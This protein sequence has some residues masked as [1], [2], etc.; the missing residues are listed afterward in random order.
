MSEALEDT[1][2][3]LEGIDQVRCQNCLGELMYDMRLT[4]DRH[5][6]ERLCAFLF[7][8]NRLSDQ[9]KQVVRYCLDC[10]RDLAQYIVK[11]ETHCELTMA[12]LRD[13]LRFQGWSYWCIDESFLEIKIFLSTL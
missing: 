1:Y 10:P 11:K 4:T 2:Q 13:Y 6:P 7:G 12:D 3:L 8:I 5:N 9:A